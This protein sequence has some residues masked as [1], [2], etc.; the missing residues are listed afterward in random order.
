MNIG[1]IVKDIIVSI[2]STAIIALISYLFDLRGMYM[3]C[4]I[5]M[6]FIILFLCIIIKQ[7]IFDLH[8]K[9]LWFNVDKQILKECTKSA[10]VN[11]FVMKGDL[12]S[13]QDQLLNKLFLPQYSNIDIRFLMSD[14][15]SDGIRNRAKEIFN[16]PHEHLKEETRIS[17]ETMISIS[18]RQNNLKLKLHNE[19][20]LV[21]F[22]ST[23]KCIFISYFLPDKYASNSSF[24]KFGKKS[25]TY[26]LYS[27]YFDYIFDNNSKEIINE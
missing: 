13:K 9:R 22:I 4:V 2:I 12:F 5:G 20:A 1:N 24:F 14:P 17:M 21:R 19:E 16:R 15:E 23:D 26:E 11:I 25:E 6:F 18:E 8:G 7:N 3:I 10:Y 27:K